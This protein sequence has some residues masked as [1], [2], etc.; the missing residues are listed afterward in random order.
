MV[1]EILCRIY[2]GG[3]VPAVILEAEEKEVLRHS[4]FQVLGFVTE[5]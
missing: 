3:A 5:E 1:A 2:T 4:V